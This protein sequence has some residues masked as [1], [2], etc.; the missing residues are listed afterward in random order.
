M[1]FTYFQEKDDLKEKEYY[2]LL[3]KFNPDI[4]FELVGGVGGLDGPWV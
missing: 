2:S 3:G 4:K 1:Q